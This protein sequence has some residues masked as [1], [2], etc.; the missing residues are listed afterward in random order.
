[1]SSTTSLLA[2]AKGSCREL[3]RAGADGLGCERLRQ[4]FKA[5]CFRRGL[6][7]SQ[8]TE[9]Y[10]RGMLRTWGIKIEA[11]PQRKVKKESR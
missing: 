10:M 8:L 6:K 4:E 1:M 5:E 7:A 2:P 9:D 3:R 11:E